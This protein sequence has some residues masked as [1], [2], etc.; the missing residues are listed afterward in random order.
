[1]AAVDTDRRIRPTT[2]KVLSRTVGRLLVRSRTSRRRLKPRSVDPIWA[3]RAFP[4]IRHNPQA[5]FS[6]YD[7]T[8]MGSCT[9]EKTTPA[10]W[11]A[12]SPLKFRGV[13]CHMDSRPF[14]SQGLAALRHR[15][16]WVKDKGKRTD[17][18]LPSFLSPLPPPPPH[19][20]T[21]PPHARV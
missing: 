21:H 9:Q 2:T 3:W 15:R 7:M 13:P 11:F 12:L 18:L 19:T 20:R 8:R 10:L 6:P 16:C 5:P 4:S 14:T 17:H 1:M